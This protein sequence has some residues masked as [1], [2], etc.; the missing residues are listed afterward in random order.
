MKPLFLHISHLASI[1]LLGLR[2]VLQSSPPS[3]TKRAV[4]SVS[5][6]K[7]LYVSLFLC[8]FKLVLLP[9][10][11]VYFQGI[12]SRLRM[13]I[14]TVLIGFQLYDVGGVEAGQTS[15]IKLFAD[16]KKAEM[17]EADPGSG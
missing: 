3:H 9:V 12:D 8:S 1:S 11:R 16:M 2:F 5:P 14:N 15:P 17:A 7:T 10:D 4:I 13:K 6:T